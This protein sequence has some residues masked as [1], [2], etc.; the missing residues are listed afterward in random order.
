MLR[1]TH[2][3]SGRCPFGRHGRHLLKHPP[4]GIFPVVR[5]ALGGWVSDQLSTEVRP[6]FI[7]PFLSVLSLEASS[8]LTRAG[9]QDPLTYRRT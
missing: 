6:S 1:V 2:S 9:G 3:I 8:P 7:V 4:H 5:R